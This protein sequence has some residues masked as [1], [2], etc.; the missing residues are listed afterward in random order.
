MNCY[1]F[2]SYI[3]NVNDVCGLNINEVINLCNIECM[4]VISEVLTSCLEDLINIRFD[5][6]LEYIINYCFNINH[7][8]GH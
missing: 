4:L 7:P 8:D 3:D 1:N 5:T 2:T 6:Q